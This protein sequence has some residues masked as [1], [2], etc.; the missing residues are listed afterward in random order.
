M[1]RH[2]LA[3]VPEGERNVTATS[4]VGKIVGRLPEDLW[5][6]AGWGGL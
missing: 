4:L 3:G 6:T 5:E 2:G 1:W